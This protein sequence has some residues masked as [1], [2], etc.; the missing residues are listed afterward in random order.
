ME[1]AF[2]TTARR[3]DGLNGFGDALYHRARFRQKNSSRFREPDS[4]DVVLEQGQLKFLFK[5]EDL[6]AQAGL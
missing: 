6:P 1:F 2:L 3:L 4:L 5:V